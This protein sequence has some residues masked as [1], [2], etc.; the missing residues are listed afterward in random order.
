VNAGKI[1]LVVEPKGTVNCI[2]TDDLDL[3]GLG[4]VRVRRASHCE[5]DEH[6][7]WW[8]DLAPVGGPK[9]GPFTKRGEALDAEVAWLRQNWL[10]GTAA[11]T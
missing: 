9:I 7:Q 10:C 1:E 6:G 3:A 4:E 11:P 2:Y 8:A 5:P